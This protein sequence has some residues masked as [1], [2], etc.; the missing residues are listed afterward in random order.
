MCSTFLPEFS[1]E[2]IYSLIY[3]SNNLEGQKIRCGIHFYIAQDVYIL[4]SFTKIW[5]TNKMVIYW[6]CTMWFDIHC[7]SRWVLWNF[8]NVCNLVPW[9]HKCMTK[10]EVKQYF[11]SSSPIE[12]QNKV[13]T[14]NNFDRSCTRKA[15]A[16]PQIS[17]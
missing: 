14:G 5:L 17:P 8:V 1:R 3:S 2:W 13:T 10:K 12:A 16:S 15:C 6:K 11:L 9:K 4:S 7:E